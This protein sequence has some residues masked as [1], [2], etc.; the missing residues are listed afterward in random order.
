MN[1]VEEV[2]RL[3]PACSAAGRRKIFD[4]LREEFAIHSLE[5]DWN[6]SAEIVLESIARSSELTQR[7]F[8]GVLAEAAFKIEVVDTLDGWTD[9]T[10]DGNHPFDFK[11]ERASRHVT[12]QTKLQRKAKG[13]PWTAEKA[14]GLN[15]P[16][17]YVVEVQ[18]TRSGL[19]AKGK[20]TRPY[21]FGEFDILAVSMEPV[22]QDWSVFRF[23]LG[24][25]LIPRFDDSGAIQ[26]Y[27]PVSLKPNEDWTD[28][29]ASCIEW[30]FDG[31]EK[32]IKGGSR[33]KKGQQTRKGKRPQR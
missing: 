18:K 17:Q 33:E 29:L 22:A 14:P 20:S 16:D 3:L 12:I 13:E 27:Q 28:N 23:T 2:K 8:R 30:L 7:M 9:V 1:P 15:D 5:S 21:R 4:M 6:V 25:W 26:V 10:P 24:R 11:L 19:D 31:T 32:T